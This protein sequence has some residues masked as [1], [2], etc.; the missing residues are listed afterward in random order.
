METPT[1]AATKV[2]GDALKQV[3]KKDGRWAILSLFLLFGAFGYVY[4]EKDDCNQ[5]LKQKDTVIEALRKDNAQ[6]QID[7]AN[8]E[9]IMRFAQTQYSHYT[10]PPPPTRKRK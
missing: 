1:Q 3:L 8:C 5:E 10:I 2:G 9:A 7:L 6:I 4:Q